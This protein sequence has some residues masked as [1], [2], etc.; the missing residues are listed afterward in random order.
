VTTAAADQLGAAPIGPDAPFATRLLMT[1]S[2]AWLFSLALAATMFSGNWG[3]AGVPVALDR[4]LLVG[5]IAALIL[6]APIGERWAFRPR[7]LHVVMAVSITFV[8]VSA[9]FSDTLMDSRARFGLLDRFGVIPFLAFVLA[10][11]IFR[12]RRDRNVLLGV[13]TV[14]GLY[15]SVTAIFESVG[16]DA[17]IFPRYITDAA[18]GIHVDR[19]RGPFVEAVANGMA[20]WACGVAASLA[21]AQ[22]RRLWLRIAC[23]AIALLCIGGVLLTLTRAVWLGALVSG[24]VATLAV[25]EVR[26]YALPIA[27]AGVAIVFVGLNVVPGFSE[28]ASERQAEQRPVWD[29]LNSN[30]AAIN[31]ALAKPLFGAGW[32]RFADKSRAYYELGDNYPMTDVR[33]VHNIYLSNLAELGGVGFLVWFAVLTIALGGAI[34]ARP[35]PDMRLWRVGLIAITINWLIVAGFGP[36]SYAF[37]NLTLWTVA[38]IAFGRAAFPLVR[39]HPTPGRT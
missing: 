35:P 5:A 19:A 12:T 17:L 7:L 2:P 23:L 1:A 18:V 21:A 13:L 4:L 9:Y 37:A 24:V 15:L 10:P 14:S 31:L 22:T 25:K 28:K 38:G 29:R 30:R 26:R 32:G 20:L 6:R 39:L 8:L 16:L 11:L 34:F 33:D 36:L 3:A 27:L